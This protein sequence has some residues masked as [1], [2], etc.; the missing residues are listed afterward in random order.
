LKPPISAFAL[1]ENHPPSIFKYKEFPENGSVIVF[2]LSFPG[3]EIILYIEKRVIYIRITLELPERIDL[4][5]LVPIIEGKP[6]TSLGN[7]RSGS[8]S[9]SDD[10]G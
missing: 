10:R 7:G 3:I 4:L 9:R 1:R 5:S 2:N 8:I 6:L